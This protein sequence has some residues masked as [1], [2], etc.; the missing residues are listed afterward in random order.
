MVDRL[1]D[2]T[3][4]FRKASPTTI[5]DS[6]VLDIPHGKSAPKQRRDERLHQVELIPLTPKATVHKHDHRHTFGT[7]DGGDRQ[8]TERV[9]MRPVTNPFAHGHPADRSDPAASS[10]TSVVREGRQ[11]DRTR[12][13]I[14]ALTAVVIASCGSATAPSGAAAVDNTGNAAAAAPSTATTSTIAAATATT[15]T[16]PLASSTTTATTSTTKMTVPVI[17]VLAPSDPT[18]AQ[19]NALFDALAANNL[20]VAVSVAHRGE[21]AFERAAGPTVAG[22]KATASSPMVVASVSKLL[23]SLAVGRLA[24]IGALDL[25]APMPWEAMGIPTESSWL[26]VTPRELLRHSAGMPVARRDWFV[27]GGGT[28]REFLPSLLVEPPTGTR[29]EWEYSNGNYCALGLLIEHIT[30]YSAVDSVDGIV[31]GPN[32]LNGVHSTEAGL[33]GDHLAH[34]RPVERLTRLGAAGTFV[35][36]MNDLAI[37]FSQLSAVDLA[38]LRQPA[39]YADQYGIGHT[40]TIQGAK[41]C[42]WSLD[43]GTTAIS[44]AISGDSVFSGGQLC[45][46]ALPA[47]ARDLGM[48]DPKPRRFP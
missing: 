42:T 44:I 19:T 7:I 12:A 13:A 24:A 26:N 31:L 35:V 46:L 6:P 29:G 16:F 1:G 10:V 20:G 30:G 9:G 27:W 23:T 4:R 40:G 36:S 25:D 33:L 18:F 17:E 15:P 28:C 21:I 45:N 37:A 22:D 41:A 47:L 43:E 48:P 39:A 3:Q 11:N 34:P 38:H 2:I 32:A 5:T 8:V 14:A